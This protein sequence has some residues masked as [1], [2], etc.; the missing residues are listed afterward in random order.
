MSVQKNEASG[1]LAFGIY[2]LPDQNGIEI[3]NLAMTS[4]WRSNMISGSNSAT[5]P[6]KVS[7]SFPVGGEVSIPIARIRRDTPLASNCARISTRCATERAWRSSLVTTRV[8]PSRANLRTTQGLLA[9]R[10]PRTK[11]APQR[12]VRIWRR[13]GSGFGLQATPFGRGSR[14]WHIRSALGVSTNCLTR[15]ET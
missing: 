11:L 14:F 15:P 10:H 7:I 6:R 8:S 13:E 12:C 4:R 3:V 1:R 9:R 5:H 2:L